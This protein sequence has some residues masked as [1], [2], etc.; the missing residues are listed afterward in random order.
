MAFD[1]TKSPGDTI[2]SA[3]WNSMV[4]DQQSRTKKT[5]GSAAP[6]STPDELGEW[7][8]DTTNNRVYVA[9]GT[10]GVNDW[11]EIIIGL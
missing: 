4:S 2:L 1:D 6:A 8:F 10:S 11:K 5:E 7:F 3:D 9:I